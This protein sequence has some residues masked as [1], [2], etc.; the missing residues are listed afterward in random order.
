MTE[1]QKKKKSPFLTGKDPPPFS[2][3]RCFVQHPPKV[4]GRGGSKTKFTLAI[5]FLPSTNRP[6]PENNDMPETALDFSPAKKRQKKGTGPLTTALHREKTFLKEDV[7]TKENPDRFVLFPIQHMSIWQMYKKHE[8][9]FWTAEEIDLAHDRFDDLTKDEQHFIKHVLAF[10]AASDG[11][12]LENLVARFMKDVQLPEARCFYGFQL[13]ME[14]VHSETYSLLIDT[15]IKDSAEKTRLFKAIETM[16]SVMKKAQWALKWVESQR[17][18]AERLVAFAIV[19]G[20]FFSGSFCAIFWLKKRGLMPGLTF[21]NELISRDE[22]L[23]CDFACLLYKKYIQKKLSQK[24][25]EEVVREAVAIEEDFVTESLPVRLIGMNATMMCEYIK[26]VANR[27]VTTLGHDPVF[28]GAKN[29]FSWMELISLQ[30]KVINTE[31]TLY[32]R[33]MLYLNCKP[34]QMKYCV[35]F[36]VFRP[37]FLK[38]GFQSIRNRAS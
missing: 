26:F 35:C 34:K 1:E 19:E 9:S 30:G 25:I 27:L 7:L 21:S 24:Q 36:R 13:A 22:G 32:Y 38:K 4:Y 17:S 12:V 37:T 28:P 6:L 31:H 23:H 5:F 20:V 18:F 8:A 14:N 15:Y 3:S 29:P 2:L 16:P 10:F 11:I 33:N